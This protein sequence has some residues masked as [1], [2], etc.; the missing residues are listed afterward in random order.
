MLK[1]CTRQTN[2]RIRIQVASTDSLTEIMFSWSTVLSVVTSLVVV[3]GVISWKRFHRNY[4]AFCKLP[5]PYKFI[6]V[7]YSR[8]PG[9]V[10]FKVFY[11]STESLTNQFKCRP[12]S[13][14]KDGD[15]AAKGVHSFN[16]ATMK[17]IPVSF[18]KLL[19]SSDPNSKRTPP[20]CFEHAPFSNKIHRK[21]L[22][23]ILFSHGLGTTWDLYTQICCNLVSYGLIVVMVEHDDGS[24]GHWKTTKKSKDGT[25]E[26]EDHFYILQHI[27][28]EEGNYSKPMG[29]DWTRKHTQQF[30]GPQVT[31]RV[32]NM[33]NVLRFISSNQFEPKLHKKMDFK[34]VFVAGHSFGGITAVFTA[35]TLRKQIGRK[36]RGCLVFEPWF[37]PKEDVDLKMKWNVPY[38]CIL[39]D[40]WW[41]TKVLWET[42]QMVFNSNVNGEQKKKIQYLKGFTH[43]DFCDACLFG[44]QW[45]MRRLGLCVKEGTIQEA[46]DLIVK[47]CVQFIA[48]LV[49]KWQQEGVQYL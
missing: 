25:Q 3:L 17:G 9:R 2:A 1:C 15:L 7:T 26:E 38:L 24:A 30:R 34:Y 18:F 16:A 14:F 6:G 32:Q 28:D 43:Q 21:K 29:S 5:G 4:P 22:P 31:Q 12:P 41:N 49:P 47:W 10:R 37:E 11:P 33:V 46:Q 20:P 48:D 23:V 45:L 36:L 39:G 35:K 44:P 27:I 40:K 19:S 8:V 13:Y 42:C